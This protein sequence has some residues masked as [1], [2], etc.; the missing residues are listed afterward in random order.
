M[1]VTVTFRHMESS[2]A[3]RDYAKKKIEKIEK[4][5]IKPIDVHF[6]MSVEKFRHIVEVTIHTNGVPIKGEGATEDMYSAIDLVIDRLEKQV[7]RYKERLKKHKSNIDHSIP[8]LKLQVIS[9][10][11][12][13][14]NPEPRVIKT[15]NFNVKPMF[16]DEAVMQM[17]LLNNEFL[18]FTNA[19]T[20]NVNVIYRRK[21]GNYGLIEPFSKTT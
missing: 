21:D 10:E 3:L 16:I 13:E 15:E 18:V 14:D 6:V 5:L 17:G 9:Q 8:T 11:N 4:Y 1:Q 19:K 12:I 2:N 7:K 20:G